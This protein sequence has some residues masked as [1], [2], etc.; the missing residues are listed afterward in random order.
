MIHVL[1]SKMRQL[2][3]LG[4]T[5]YPPY[6]VKVNHRSAFL[7]PA[8][9]LILVISYTLIKLLELVKLRLL[10]LTSEMMTLLATSLVL[11][12][13]WVSITIIS[14]N[15]PLWYYV[16]TVRA[17]LLG[18]ILNT[19]QYGALQCSTSSWELF[20]VLSQ[21]WCEGLILRTGALPLKNLPAP[22]RVLTASDAPFLEV[23]GTS[24]RTPTR[25]VF[26]IFNTCTGWLF[27]YRAPIC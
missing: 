2:A 16:C 10:K 9:V 3:S 24:I 25:M 26:I 18:W 21:G 7:F 12:M 22:P 15:P 4:F 11:S 20:L 5:H 1:C 27:D 19:D 13:L 14:S 23:G 6:W 8:L 17:K